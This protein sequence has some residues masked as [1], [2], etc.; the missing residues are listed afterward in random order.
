MLSPGD[1][2]RYQRQILLKEFGETAQ[3]KLLNAKVLVIGAGGLGCPALHYLASAGIGHLG[4]IDFDSVDLSNLHRQTLYSTKDI[5]KPKVEAAAER[6]RNIN[7]EIN[8][9]TH[10]FRLDQSNTLE[11][12]KHYDLILDGS[13][14]YATRYLV[15]DACLILGKTLVYGAVMRYE[16]QVGVFNFLKNSVRS[17][18][19]RHLFPVPDGLGNKQSCSEVGILGVLPGIIGTLQATEAIKIISGIGDPLINK[20]LIYNA[21]R[22]SFYAMELFAEG[23]IDYPKNETEFL[24]YNYQRFCSIALD[25][26]EIS[27]IQFETLRQDYSS[28]VID[29]REAGEQPA[30][31]EFKH[32]NI[33]LSG[34]EPELS[35]LN[36]KGPVLLFCKTGQRSAKAAHL[37]KQ[38]FPESQVYSL[39]GGIIAWKEKHL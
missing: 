37:I 21:L 22:V 18:N 36:P 9:Q 24:E 33:P 10:A 7:P 23:H 28:T 27:S 31:K 29:V 14:D 19:Y 3:E 20:V 26:E 35:K 30:V 34:L 12:F 4:L 11:L 32:I 15:N 39:K 38:H 16:G 13:D 8:I 5:G 25:V 1:Q 6:L 2:I 17:C